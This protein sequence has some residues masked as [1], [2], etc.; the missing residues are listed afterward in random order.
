MNGAHDAGRR[1]G[2]LLGEISEQ[3]PMESVLRNDQALFLRGVV[4]GL[5]EIRPSGA[6]DGVD[7]F[8]EEL[9]QA[10]RRM[11]GEHSR[12][13]RVDDLPDE[14]PSDPPLPDPRARLM[15]GFVERELLRP[16]EEGKLP[17]VACG[18]LTYGMDAQAWVEAGAPGAWVS[19]GRVWV[20]SKD[21]CLDLLDR[22]IFP[23]GKR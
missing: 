5:R 6:D 3:M 19:E 20:C 7:D 10:V 8:V 23:R 2:R 16:T 14:P 13:V 1:L 4:E 21:E 9:T 11:W 17:C 18:A 12:G 15:R 22:T